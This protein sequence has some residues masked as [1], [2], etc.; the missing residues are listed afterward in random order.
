M[1]EVKL[2]DQLWVLFASAL[3]LFMQAGFLCVESGLTR[4]KN[5]INVAI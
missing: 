5:S 3:V 2:T 1:P 4:T